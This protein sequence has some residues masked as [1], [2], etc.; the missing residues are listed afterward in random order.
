MTVQVSREKQ[1]PGGHPEEDVGGGSWA[2]KS[3]GEE[4]RSGKVQNLTDQGEKGVQNAFRVSQ[5]WEPT[6]VQDQPRLHSLGL[7]RTCIMQRKEPGVVAH[8]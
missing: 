3:W 2:Q 6:S 5:A 4:S 1:R 8:T 7:E